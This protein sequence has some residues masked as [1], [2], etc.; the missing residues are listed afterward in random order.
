L[1]WFRHSFFTSLCEVNHESSRESNVIEI[2]TWRLADC[3]R[4]IGLGL[5]TASH[6]THAGFLQWR[7]GNANGGLGYNYDTSPLTDSNLK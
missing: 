2:Q 3:G 1:N 5:H 4:R 7:G 6:A